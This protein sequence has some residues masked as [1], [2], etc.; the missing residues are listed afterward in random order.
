MYAIETRDLTKRYNGFT[1]V[2]NLTMH[3]RSGTVY[4][5][6]GPN[7]AGKSTTMKLLLGIIKPGG[8]ELSVAARAIP[9][10][11]WRYCAMLA[12]S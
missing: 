4:G 2:D 11:G 6:L 10:S 9:A 3:V 8:G 7:G 12:R 5:F 1:A